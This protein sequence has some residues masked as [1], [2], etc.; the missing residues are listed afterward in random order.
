MPLPG[1][2]VRIASDGE[3][4]VTGPG[5]LQ[6]WVHHR[7]QVGLMVGHHDVGGGRTDVLE[8]LDGHARPCGAQPHRRPASLPPWPTWPGSRSPDSPPAA[9]WPF[10]S[11]APAPWAWPRPCSPGAPGR[12]RPNPA[13]SIRRCRTSHR[14][15]PEGRPPVL[16]ARAPCYRLL[17]GATSVG[18]AAALP[19]SLL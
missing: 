7:V 18:P 9:A 2:A 13:R 12:K 1:C 10:L 3:I 14:R 8:A 16:A 17:R 15:P 19:C 4:L 5:V 6:G 11:W